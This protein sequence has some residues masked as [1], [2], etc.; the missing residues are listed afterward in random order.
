MDV[1]DYHLLDDGFGLDSRDR[2]ETE[3]LNFLSSQLIFLK[4][5]V[6]AAESFR[7]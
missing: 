6:G 1:A 4:I 3:I 5:S 7:F 2:K